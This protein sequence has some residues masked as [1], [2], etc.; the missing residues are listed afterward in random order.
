MINHLELFIAL[1][2]EALISHPIRLPGFAQEQV[3]YFHGRLFGTWQS[4]KERI[5]K[6]SLSIKASCLHKI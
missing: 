1:I 5:L 3:F 6:G 2:L 4:L